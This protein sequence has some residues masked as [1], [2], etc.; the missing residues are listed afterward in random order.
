MENT[1]TLLSWDSD[2]FG[3]KVGRIDVS[4]L[5]KNELTNLLSDAKTKG[6]KLLYWPVNP[7]DNVLNQLAK[8]NG[9]LLVDEKV[10][11]VRSI[12]PSDKQLEVSPSVLSCL[13]KTATERTLSLSLQSGIYSR[14]NTDPNFTHNEFNKLYTEWIEKSLSGK[15]AK[16]VL[17]FIEKREEVGLLTLG[18]KNN[19]ADIGLLAVDK[20]FRGKSIGTSLMHA[21]FRKAVEWGYKEIQVTTQL[22]NS[23]A[24]IFYEKMGFRKEH[25]VNIYHF[26][27]N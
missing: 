8:E 3:Y 9:G 22:Q 23:A 6:F 5:S 18:E 13:N 11:F 4:I 17:V 15:I 14:Y 25:I 1:I 10:T 12:L 24:C 7:K 20:D 16:E 27:F 19:R 26:W 21:A 2:F